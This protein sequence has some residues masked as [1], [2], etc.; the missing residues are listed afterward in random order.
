MHA[1]RISVSLTR[2][3][4]ECLKHA[5]V[6]GSAGI[7]I[8]IKRQGKLI[9]SMTA[10]TRGPIVSLLTDFGTRDH[11]VAVMKAVIAG[12]APD[13]RVIDITHEVEPFQIRQGAYL[14]SQAW[15]W[16]P[17][18]TVHVAVV[19][20]GVG[21]TRRP[22]AAAANGHYFVLPDNG[23]LSMISVEQ[24]L[25]REIRNEALLLHPVS[26]TFHGRDIFAP[27]AAHIAS[28][29]SFEDT[30][31][32]VDDW[33][34]LPPISC[35]VLHIDRFGNIVTSLRANDNPDCV[36]SLHGI[37]ISRH[38]KNYAAAPAGEFFLIEGSGGYLEI[39]EREGSAASR[40]GSRVGDP[41]ILL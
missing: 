39:S 5:R 30:G 24:P 13:A 20:P 12:I 16:F 25:V 32:L 33:V 7:V 15:R 26:R 3:F 35:F 40:L 18:G 22:I 21:S 29:F 41:V 19:D 36:V 11:Y 2:R 17:R 34:R 14:L 10:P 8:E 23:L 9:L 37:T 27:T 6:D 31:P 1:R 38:A 4:H 28:G